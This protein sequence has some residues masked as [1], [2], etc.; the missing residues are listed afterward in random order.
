MTSQIST[1]SPRSA[2]AAAARSRIVSRGLLVRFVSVVGSSVGFY[3]PLAVVPLF[4]KQ[5]GPASVAALP[6]VALLLASVAGEL[7][8]PRLLARVGYRCA[9]ALGLTLLGAPTLVLT[10]SDSGW[11]I[12][13]VSLVRGAGFAICVVA[14]GAL[15]ATLI[16]ADRRGEGF[17]LV[18]LIG[19]VPGMLAL[20]AG[21]WASERWGDAP[22]FVATAVV[23]LLAVLSVPALPRAAVSGVCSGYPGV[24]KGLRDRA[25]TRP[26]TV[27][28]TSAAAVGVLVT[29]VPL[30]T[31]AQ[32]AWV[33]TAA[34]LA[35]PAA[36]TVARCVAG[37]LG[38]RR[39]HANLLKPGVLLSATGIAALAAT[40][41]P[42]AVIGGAIVF[43]TGYGVLQNATLVLMYSRAP[44]GGEGAVSAIWN[45]S[46]DLGMAAGAL[47]AGLLATPLGY[48]T[49]FVLIAALALS[50]LIVVGRDVNMTMSV[51]GPIAG[52]RDELDWMTTTPRPMSPRTS[53][54]RH[55]PARADQDGNGPPNP[56]QQSAP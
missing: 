8:T 50:A 34:L 2:V 7:V 13:A 27:F 30:A 16:P 31:T 44:A 38:D 14:G 52:P 9:L 54:R 29:F 12:V 48:S 42:P 21:L 23:T 22:V 56:V 55:D 36:S 24:L 39:G 28:A 32:A 53:R 25:L 35:Q 18:G 1:V 10:I 5:T 11:V 15:T 17:A 45:A 19:G 4:A 47:G 26:A 46:Y 3:L 40:G 6:T 51:D 20:P 37:R 49:T 33:A 41:S 43:G